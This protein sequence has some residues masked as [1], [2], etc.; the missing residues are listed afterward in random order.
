LAVR[1]LALSLLL[2]AAC[3]QQGSPAVSFSV[4]KRVPASEA[5]APAT[6]WTKEQEGCVDRTLA[7]RGL[8]AY[9]SPQGTMYAGGTPLFDEASGKSTSRQAF[10]QRLRPDVLAGCD[11]KP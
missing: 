2:A 5:G 6:G 3:Q 10:L 8:D 4:V 11:V 7:A 9:G 1:F